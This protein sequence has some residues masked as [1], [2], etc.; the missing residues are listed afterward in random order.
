MLAKK[1]QEFHAPETVVGIA[2]G[3]VI[4]GATVASLLGR[5]VFSIKL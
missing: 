1:I 4:V 2:H 3:G 5:G